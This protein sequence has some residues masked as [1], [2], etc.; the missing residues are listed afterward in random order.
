M[1]LR[2]P[3]LMVLLRK[4]TQVFLLAC[5]A[6]SPGCLVESEEET[7]VESLPEAIDDDDDDSVESRALKPLGSSCNTSCQCQLGTECKLTANGSKTCQSLDLFASPLPPYTPCALSCQ[8]P[9]GQSCFFRSW[10][11]YGECKPGKTLCTSPCDCGIHGT[12]VNGK[13]QLAFGPFPQCACSKNCPFN[14]ACVNGIC[15]L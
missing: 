1:P 6:V 15:Q 8:C 11:K 5:L 4:V 10:D 7:P 13:C 12:C 3:Q 9:Y 14:K 2:Y